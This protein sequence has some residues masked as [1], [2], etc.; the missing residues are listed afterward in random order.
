MTR[1][2]RKEEKKG[3]KEE[4]E[5]TL[6]EDYRYYCIRMYVWRVSELSIKMD[7]SAPVFLYV[8][9]PRPGPTG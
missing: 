9:A 2:D 7:V 3:N 5:V 1:V 4:K 8:L 6:G